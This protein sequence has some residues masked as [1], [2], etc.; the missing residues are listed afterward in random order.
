MNVQNGLVEPQ[1][2]WQTIFELLQSSP[3]RCVLRRQAR[4][5]LAI[6]VL[7]T[8]DR[9]T[10]KIFKARLAD[11]GGT[12]IEDFAPIVSREGTFDD[13]FAVLAGMV[14]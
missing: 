10:V 14:E 3:S 7:E 4:R 5:Y 6:R 8:A 11:G 9:H 1:R 12:Q 2:P 13:A